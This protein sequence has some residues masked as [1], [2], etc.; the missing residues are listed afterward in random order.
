MR[1]ALIGLGASLTV[2]AVVNGLAAWQLIGPD[3]EKSLG[4][5]RGEVLGW[6]A[7]LLAAGLLLA[8]LGIAMR[9]VR[10][11]AAAE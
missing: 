1:V 10:Q 11:R 8:A 9:T 2:S 7:C 4:L 6:Y 3:D 5:T